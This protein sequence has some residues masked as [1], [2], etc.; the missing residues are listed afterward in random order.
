MGVTRRRVNLA[1]CHSERREESP[2]WYR[3]LVRSHRTKAGG[4]SGAATTT[5]R[6][7]AALT[8][9]SREPCWG[10]LAS[11]GMTGCLLLDG[12][13]ESDQL[14]PQRSH[15]RQRRDPHEAHHE[16]ERAV[17][18]QLRPA[19]ALRLI[20]HP[21]EDQGHLVHPQQ[22]RQVIMDVLRNLRRR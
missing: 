1:R 5:A 12:A 22:R 4:W 6:R 11:L 9:A 3:R 18:K 13:Q 10:F 15:Q 21:E 17:E 2:A 7:R 20:E 8:N 19:L 16:I 14:F